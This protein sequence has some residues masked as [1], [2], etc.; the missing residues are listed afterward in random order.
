MEAGFLYLPQ[1]HP[2]ISVQHTNH[3]ATFA[4]CACVC[5]H[6]LCVFSTLFLLPG[7]TFQSY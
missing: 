5:V 1:F 4:T 6:P 3:H 2:R 7:V